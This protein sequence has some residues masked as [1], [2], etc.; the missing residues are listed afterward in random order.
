MSIRLLA[1]SVL[2]TLP[3]AIG[4]TASAADTGGYPEPRS[5][6]Q[7]F[8]QGRGYAPPRGSYKDDPAPP[9]PRQSEYRERGPACLPRQVIHERLLQEGWRDFHDH[10]LR[11]SVAV[12]RAHRASGDLYVLTVDRCSGEIVDAHRAR[13]EYREYREVSGPY[14]ARPYGFARRGGG[15]RHRYW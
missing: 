13:R 4:Q 3:M 5:Y 15:W 9:P 6:E 2:A 1:A 10:E 7:E 12:V 8:G 14:Y 11:G